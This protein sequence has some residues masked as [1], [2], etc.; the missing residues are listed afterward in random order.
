MVKIFRIPCS[1]NLH[2]RTVRP[3]LS[4]HCFLVECCSFNTTGEK[5]LY[6]GALF[7]VSGFLESTLNV[8]VAS[9]DIVH[10]VKV[11]LPK[12]ASGRKKAFFWGLWWTVADGPG[13]WA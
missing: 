8:V 4:E 12:V 9:L 1:A 6:Q 5:A 7:A 10:R 2:A 3:A 13:P 11:A